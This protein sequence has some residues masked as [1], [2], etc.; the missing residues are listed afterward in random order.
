MHL[1][2]LHTNKLETVTCSV[3][4]GMMVAVDE[5]F[6][7]EFFMVLFKRTCRKYLVFKQ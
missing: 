1:L 7:G 5:H 3:A 2:N 6:S 4:F